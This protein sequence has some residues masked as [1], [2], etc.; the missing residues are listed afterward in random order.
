MNNGDL[1]DLKAEESGLLE[2]E[3][4]QRAEWRAQ[5]CHLMSMKDSLLCQ[6]SRL[7]WLREGDANTS[8]FHGYI[9][10]RRLKNEI[11]ALL[12][13]NV[14]YREPVTMKEGVQSYFEQHFEEKMHNRPDAT[15]LILPFSE[16]E[17]KEAVWDCEGA[18]SPGPNGYN[19]NFI[20]DFWDILKTDF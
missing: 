7:K 19:F 20:K 14:W 16:E 8:F 18:K 9:N 10:K 2:E 12:I 5:F 15:M 11:R 6:K 13:N 1:L 3:V 4:V 17:V